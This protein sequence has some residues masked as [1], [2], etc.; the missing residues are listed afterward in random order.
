MPLRAERRK[1][2]I[3]SGSYVSPPPGWSRSDPAGLGPFVTRERFRAPD[4]QVVEWTSREHRKQSGRLDAGRGS[5]WWAP[6][7]VGWWIAGLF[8]VGSLCF[9]VGALPGFASWV[10]DDAD[11]VTFFVGSI[12]FTSAAYLQ[13]LQT[14]N[15]PHGLRPATA[16]EPG[17]ERLRFWTWEP[18]R[19]DW[20]ASVIQF[21]GTVFFNVTT[22][23]AVDSS[24]NATQAH[25][26]VWVPD[27]VGSICFLVASGLAWFEVS[28][29]WWSWRTGSLSWRI[30]ALNLAGSIA[31]GLS[32]MASKIVPTT[33]DP[34]NIVLVNLGTA[35]GG[36][37]F[38]V[39]A[40][41]LFPERTA[42]RA[43]TPAPV[44]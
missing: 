8:A 12:F 11:A 3:L 20:S 13:Y 24:L 7:A 33:G 19:I 31:F 6:T 30:A 22:L 18:A 39:G 14:L 32:A 44:S 36:L 27:M 1:L 38:L 23:A 40:L 21:V 2:T 16:A 10:G 5:T 15:A 17:D 35:I 37:C 41:F 25:R 29:G 9:T 28:H 26:L 43:A 42:S 34:R 4:G